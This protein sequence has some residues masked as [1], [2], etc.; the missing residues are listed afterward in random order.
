MRVHPGGWD[1]VRMV[2]NLDVIR[3]SNVLPVDDLNEH[4]PSPYCWCSP[5]E[6][7][8]TPTLWVHNSADRREM[9]EA[10]RRLD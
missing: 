1:V 6:D 9:Y 5:M 7:D 2:D 8:E 3:Q 4:D 10:S